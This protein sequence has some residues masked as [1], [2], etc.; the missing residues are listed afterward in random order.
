MYTLGDV[1]YLMNVGGSLLSSFFDRFKVPRDVNAENLNNLLQVRDLPLKLDLHD[2]N[3]LSLVCKSLNVYKSDMRDS[4]QSHQSL[5][6]KVESTVVSIFSNGDSICKKYVEAN[7]NYAKGY[8]NNCS[9]DDIAFEIFEGDKKI[10][11]VI[12]RKNVKFS[13]YD[14]N[15]TKVLAFP[16]KLKLSNPDDLDEDLAQVARQVAINFSKVLEGNAKKLANEEWKYDL[17]DTY[18]RSYSGVVVSYS[19]ETFFSITPL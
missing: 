1:G 19:T 3:R 17:G 8:I 6:S 14:K 15:K 9:L 18:Y 7:V 10:E 4:K 12:Q 5:L 16:Y 13:N 11:F 2:K